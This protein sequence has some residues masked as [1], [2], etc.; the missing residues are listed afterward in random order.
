VTSDVTSGGV[1][2]RH[3]ATLRILAVCTAN[4]CRSPVVER[5]LTRHLSAAGWPVQVRSAGVAGGRLGVHRDTLAA[6]AEVGVD[7]SDH[8]SRRLTTALLADDGADLVVTSTREHLR[9][10]VA[11]DPGAW[12][13]TFTLRELARRAGEVSNMANVWNVSDFAAWRAALGEGRRAADLM[14]PDPADDLDDPYGGPARHHV[15]MVHDVEALSARIAHLVP[16]P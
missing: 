14:R 15:T 13:R 3:P 1:G 9:E 12:P 16:R 4:V 10:V 5:L 7:L 6:A 11:L 2:D 8:G